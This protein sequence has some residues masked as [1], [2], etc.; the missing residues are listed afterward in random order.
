MLHGLHEVRQGLLG[1]NIPFIL[2]E[3]EAPLSLPN[4]IKKL[5][6]QPSSLISAL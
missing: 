1:L 4:L 2:L 3:Q 6:Y 5:M